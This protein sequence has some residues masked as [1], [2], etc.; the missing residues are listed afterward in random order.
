M[1]KLRQFLKTH[2][3]RKQ[4][5]LTVDSTGGIATQKGH[6]SV[7]IPQL[8]EHTSL[9]KIFLRAKRTAKNFLNVNCLVNN[10]DI[11]I[12]KL[13]YFSCNTKEIISLGTKIF[14]VGEK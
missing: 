7:T 12:L 8:L 13:L 1:G 6:I 4:V 3:K 10:F 9:G 11:D 5:N 14:I 2:S